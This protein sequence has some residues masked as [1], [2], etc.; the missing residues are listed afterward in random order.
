MARFN[1]TEA[2][3]YGGQGGSGFFSIAN[4]GEIKKVRF[5]YDT[6]EDIEGY[7]VHEVE[8]DGKKRYVNCL[9]AYNEPIDNC[10]FCKAQRRQQVK[11]FIPVYDVADGKVKFWER[12]KK[13]FARLSGLCARYPHL[14]EQ[15][16]EIERH[17]VKGSKDTFY[18]IMPSV[19][20]TPDGT[21]ISD[22]VDEMP[23]VIGGLVLDKTPS[24]MEY[25][26]SYGK[27]PSSDNSQATT[28]SQITRRTPSANRE[29]F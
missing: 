12:G 29:V 8:V 19:G 13:M 25:Y 18:D 21:K 27:F 4:D 3:H 10:P 20:K 22:L 15:E 6:A 9:R 11:A 23:K 1:Y 2:E 28:N 16:F 14:V 5:L 26:L 7:A 24:E 17:G